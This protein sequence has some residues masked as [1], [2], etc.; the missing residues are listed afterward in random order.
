MKRLMRILF[1]LVPLFLLT[2]CSQQVDVPEDQYGILFRMG[3][4]EKTVSGPAT[5]EKGFMFEHVT[6]I[7]KKDS[8][9]LGGGKFI[10]KYSVS[11]PEKY[12]RAIGSSCRLY[13]KIE[14]E[15]ARYALDGKVVNTSAL[16]FEMING[17]DLPI[18][19]DKVVDRDALTMD[20]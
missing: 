3:K 11:E 9:E 2:G 13:S 7:D 6:F 5:L 1:I 20:V 10:V 18:V 16:L 15:L 17:M 19:L 8:V 4:I 12:H 14:K